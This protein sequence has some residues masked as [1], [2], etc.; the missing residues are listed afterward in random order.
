MNKLDELTSELKILDA[1]RHKVQKD[2]LTITTLNKNK[3][4]INNCINNPV[5]F[6]SKIVLSDKF[7]SGKGCDIF[8]PIDISTELLTSIVLW[9]ESKRK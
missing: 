4:M 8:I 3:E 1:K 5:R 9:L 7:D 2:I 6:D